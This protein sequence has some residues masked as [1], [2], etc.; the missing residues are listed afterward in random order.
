MR[1]RERDRE[2]RRGIRGGD[3]GR[4]LILSGGRTYRDITGAIHHTK[5]TKPPDQA[6]HSYSVAKHRYLLEQL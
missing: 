1:H 2:R 4:F 5:S 3:R 6:L